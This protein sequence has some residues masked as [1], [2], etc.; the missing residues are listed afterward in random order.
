MPTRAGFASPNV[1]GVAIGVRVGVHTTMLYGPVSS[2]WAPTVPL[3]G[4][5][6]TTYVP[7]SG[8]VTRLSTWS[9]TP[10]PA[11]I[12]PSGPSSVMSVDA[13]ETRSTV[14]MSPANPAN[15]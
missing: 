9:F 2:S 12:E 7:S 13:P 6:R 4:S 3:R 14:T 10:A 1:I 8:S 15:V 5:T 11:T